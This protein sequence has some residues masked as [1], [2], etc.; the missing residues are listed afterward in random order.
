MVS[1]WKSFLGSKVDITTLLLGKVLEA[2]SIIRLSDSDALS[3]CVLSSLVPVWM[4]MWLGEPRRSSDSS[5]M[6][7]FGHF[8]VGEQFLSI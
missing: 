1:G 2:F 8:V 5:S 3:C 4:M 7:H 6:A